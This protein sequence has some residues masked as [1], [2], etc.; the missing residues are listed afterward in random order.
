MAFVDH[1]RRQTLDE[2]GG[3]EQES[4]GV[5]V[6]EVEAMAAHELPRDETRGCNKAAMAPMPIHFVP[7]DDGFR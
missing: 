5:V 4:G 2:E 1:R 7:S 3:V 6:D